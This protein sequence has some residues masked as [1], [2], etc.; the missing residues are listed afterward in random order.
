MFKITFYSGSGVFLSLGALTLILEIITGMAISYG[1]VLI[2]IMI[3]LAVFGF[4]KLVKQL[5]R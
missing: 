2:M 4:M 3:I 1:L 5:D